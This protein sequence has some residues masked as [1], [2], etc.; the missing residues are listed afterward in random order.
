M[1]A[2]L[3]FLLLVLFIVPIQ[4][5]AFARLPE[6][7]RRAI[8]IG[9][10][11]ALALIPVHFGGMDKAT[12]GVILVG[13]LLAGAELAVIIWVKGR[14]EGRRGLLEATRGQINDLARKYTGEG[15]AD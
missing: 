10:V 8:G 5:L 12:W 13:F 2:I 6:L 14:R 7:A 11:M 9:T 4:H 3:A 1:P 15:E